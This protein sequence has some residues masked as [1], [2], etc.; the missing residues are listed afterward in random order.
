[1]DAAAQSSTDECIL[2]PHRVGKDGY[3]TVKRGGKIYA[4]HR[5][6]CEMAHGQP[7]EGAHAAHSCGQRRCI[8]PRHLRWATAKENVH[9][10]FLHGTFPHGERSGNASLNN[11]Q[12][13]QILNDAR[14]QCEIA[15]IYGVSQSTISNIKTGRRWRHVT[16]IDG[17]A[18]RGV[19]T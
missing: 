17:R 9:D 2:W 13:A 3:G 19:N 5:Q 6:V 14:A 4:A 15:D 7:F 18:G 10:M 16:G 12:V 1:M 8:N 11:T